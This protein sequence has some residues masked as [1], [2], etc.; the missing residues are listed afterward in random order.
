[1]AAE[2]DALIAKVAPVLALGCRWLVL[3]FDDVPARGADAVVHAA[4]TTRMHRHLERRGVRL[5][6]VLRMYAG[7]A[8]DP[9]VVQL[10]AWLPADVGV[11][12]G[13]RSPCGVP[14]D[15]GRPV[16]AWRR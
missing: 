2:G 13:D 7:I 10:C 6:V 9:D 11:M 1:M 15:Y 16:A 14:C 12:G 8:P 4:I 3:A 5:D